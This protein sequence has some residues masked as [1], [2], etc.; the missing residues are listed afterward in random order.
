[1]PLLEVFECKWLEVL[2]VEIRGKPRIIWRD[3]VTK[4]F[5][6]K[7]TIKITVVVECEEYEDIPRKRLHVHGFCEY[8][9]DPSPERSIE[10]Q[11][12][13]IIDELIEDIEIKAVA[14][15]F[16]AFLEYC[17]DTGRLK[18]DWEVEPDEYYNAG[19][20]EC[21]IKWRHKPEERWREYRWYCTI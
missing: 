5:V 17:E 9:L 20:C 18:Q 10:E 3:A 14:L 21:H 15:G 1:M 11:V 6:R 19:L 7:H 2:R 8:Y 4:R 12:Q 13:E 16:D